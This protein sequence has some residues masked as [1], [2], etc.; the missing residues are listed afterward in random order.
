MKTLVSEIELYFGGED[1]YMT[2]TQI[3][4]TCVTELANEAARLTRQQGAIHV[5]FGP[6][7]PRTKEGEVD[8]DTKKRR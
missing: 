5:S 7:V 4:A 1:P 8:Y 3:K 6:P 2:L